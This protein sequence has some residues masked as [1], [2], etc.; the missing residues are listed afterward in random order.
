MEVRM[1]DTYLDPEL[2]L[3]RFNRLMSELFRG[4]IA[5]N[6]FQPWEVEILLDIELCPLSARRRWVALRQYQRAVQRQLQKGHGPPM[7]FSEFLEKRGRKRVASV[8]STE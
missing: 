4:T 7:K 5:R 1:T 2:M 8:M 6:A 3:G